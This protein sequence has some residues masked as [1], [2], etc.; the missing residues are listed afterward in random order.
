MK[1][2]FLKHI[3][4][5]Y[6]EE[7]LYIKFIA[8]LEFYMDK[9]YFLHI[10][11]DFFHVSQ[12]FKLEQYSQ[13]F[14]QSIIDEINR[15]NQRAKF[16]SPKSPLVEF[17]TQSIT[18]PTPSGSRHLLEKRKFDDEFNDFNDF[19]KLKV[20]ETKEEVEKE[21]ESMRINFIRQ[22]NNDIGRI[23]DDASIRAK[24]EFE[25][26]T[27]NYKRLADLKEEEFE[28]KANNIMEDKK[29]EFEENANKVM[30]EK[31]EAF[32]TA[33]DY[34]IHAKISEVDKK[35]NECYSDI[36]EINEKLDALKVK[37]K[38]TRRKQI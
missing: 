13:Y 24:Q 25:V 10:I 38:P 20:I 28:E 3:K 6:N 36:S 19:K 21:M 30:K 26:S 37:K 11:R 14:D 29:V 1:G 32:N 8:S 33:T 16:G 31:T 27:E 5:V 2:S 12:E 9:N 17:Y 4:E 23:M 18:S 34:I 22:I 35:I 7:I 15:I